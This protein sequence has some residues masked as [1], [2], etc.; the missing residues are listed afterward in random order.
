MITNVCQ[1]DCMADENWLEEI[2]HGHVNSYGRLQE[3]ATAGNLKLGAF[4]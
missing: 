1:T 2:P 4:Y 3:S